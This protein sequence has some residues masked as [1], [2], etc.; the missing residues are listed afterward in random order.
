M[1]L[2]KKN[3]S[4]D[5]FEPGR[6][7]VRNEF[8]HT[9]AAAALALTPGTGTGAGIQARWGNTHNRNAS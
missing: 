7:S 8:G 9:Y 2:L 6:H 1:Q 5:G 3:R 4:W